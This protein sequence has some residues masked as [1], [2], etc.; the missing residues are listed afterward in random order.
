MRLARRQCGE[1]LGERDVKAFDADRHAE[2]EPVL[3]AFDLGGGHADLHELAHIAVVGR[4]PGDVDDDAVD[5]RQRGQH[6]RGR[7][8]RVGTMQH[9]IARRRAARGVEQP[10]AEIGQGELRQRLPLGDMVTKALLC[11]DLQRHTSLLVADPV[12]PGPAE[13]QRVLFS[14]RRAQRQPGG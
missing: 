12:G 13:A 4:F 14:V 6:L 2:I 8:H 10:M 7:P 5:R 11:A 9:D 3:V 1:H